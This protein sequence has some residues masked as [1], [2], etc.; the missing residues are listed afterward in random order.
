MCCGFD[1]SVIQEDAAAP[2]T[3]APM[4]NVS[5]GAAVGRMVRG[6]THMHETAAKDKTYVR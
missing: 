5:L 2:P 1:V 4:A 3:L 6:V